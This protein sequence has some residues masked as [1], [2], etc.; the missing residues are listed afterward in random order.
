MKHLPPKVRQ[1]LWLGLLGVIIFAL[2][3]PLT[4]LAVGLSLIHI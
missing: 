2:T 3:L 4:R 1:G